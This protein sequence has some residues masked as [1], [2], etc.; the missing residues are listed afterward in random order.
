MDREEA[1]EHLKALRT[2]ERGAVNAPRPYLSREQAKARQFQAAANA[3]ALEYA[4]Q[5]LEG[6]LQRTCPEPIQQED[7]YYCTACGLRWDTKEDKPSC[8]RKM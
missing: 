6:V 4:I 3:A 1:L 8:A 7:E 2:K 5:E